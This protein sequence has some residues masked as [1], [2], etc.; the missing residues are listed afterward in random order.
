MS[1]RFTR[2]PWTSMEDHVLASCYASDSMDSL[3]A[4]I[5]R[6]TETSIRARASYL[7]LQKRTIQPQVMNISASA[8]IEILEAQLNLK[9]A[10]AECE[11][12]AQRLKL[13]H[14]R[15]RIAFKAALKNDPNITLDQL[16]KENAKEFSKLNGGVTNSARKV[17]ER[18]IELDMAS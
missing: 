15:C 5:P 8:T 10:E 9:K 11:A 17:L 12:A 3:L 4:K 6:R 7:K 14:E 13:F 18:R 2:M 16:F 1:D